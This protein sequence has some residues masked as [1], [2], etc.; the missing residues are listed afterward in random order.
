VATIE[1]R[2]D[3]E[4]YSG[5]TRENGGNLDVRHIGPGAQVALPVLAPTLWVIPS[6][7]SRWAAGRGALIVISRYQ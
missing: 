4:A 6:T 5:P 1:L 7:V 3:P 2:V